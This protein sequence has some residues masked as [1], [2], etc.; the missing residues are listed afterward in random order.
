MTPPESGI[1]AWTTAATP[2]AAAAPT[3]TATHVL[4]EPAK[5]L[6]SN[7][8]RVDALDPRR[9]DVRGADRV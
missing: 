3:T 9:W 1:A 4:R 7:S 8:F 6:I 5:N 2:A